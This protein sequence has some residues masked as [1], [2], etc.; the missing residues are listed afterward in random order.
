MIFPKTNAAPADHLSCCSLFVTT[1]HCRYLL[2]THCLLTRVSRFRDPS[3]LVRNLEQVFVGS[4]SFSS[5]TGYSGSVVKIVVD[6]TAWSVETLGPLMTC[7]APNDIWICVVF[8]WILVDICSG[9]YCAM[10]M[11]VA[12][13]VRCP[14]NF[15]GR[16]LYFKG[17]E[18]L[19]VGV[20]LIMW[21]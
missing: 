8:F 11:Y 17:L 19:R 10:A 4:S 13:Y 18:R 2:C 7:L 12:M 3:R 5:P 21:R 1:F 15:D 9:L 14:P 20:V 16:D 6:V